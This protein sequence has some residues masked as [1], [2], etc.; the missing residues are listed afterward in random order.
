M[1][2]VAVFKLECLKMPHK[3]NHFA[4]HHFASRERSIKNVQNKH[5]IRGASNNVCIS[6]QMTAA[7]PDLHCSFQCAFQ[8]EGKQVVKNI[9]TLSPPLSNDRY[10][11][12]HIL[13]RREFIRNEFVISTHSWIPAFTGVWE[14]ERR[15][16]DEGTMQVMA[17]LQKGCVISSMSK[18][19]DGLL[20]FK[21]IWRL[22]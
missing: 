10:S 19:F 21:P 9:L 20:M 12:L 17:C 13:R 5:E 8:N 14:V 4:L 1:A 15:G 2:V 3:L 7:F 11:T 18:I 6:H 22:T 16:Y